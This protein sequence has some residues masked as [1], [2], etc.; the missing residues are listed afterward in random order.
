MRLKNKKNIW[1]GQ[2]LD[3]SNYYI[4]CEIP[5]CTLVLNKLINPEPWWFFRVSKFM[6]KTHTR[7][8]ACVTCLTTHPL[9]SIMQNNT[10]TKKVFQ[11]IKIEINNSFDKWPSFGT[12]L[13]VHNLLETNFLNVQTKNVWYNAWETVWTMFYEKKCL[14]VTGNFAL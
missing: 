9:S 11:L 6:Q 7:H 8:W 12:N 1:E 10:Q 4:I 5:S 14:K 13:K 3:P 2:L